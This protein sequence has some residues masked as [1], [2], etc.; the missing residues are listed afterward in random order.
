MRK[1]QSGGV[2]VTAL[3]ALSPGALSS[4]AYGPEAILVVLVTAGALTPVRPRTSGG[5]PH[6]TPADGKI[7]VMGNHAGRGR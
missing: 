5:I 1:R 6:G 4:T 2:A 7:C 3:A